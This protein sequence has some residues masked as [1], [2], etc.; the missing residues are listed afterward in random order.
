MEMNRERITKFRLI[1]IVQLLEGESIYKNCEISFHCVVNQCSSLC[2]PLYVNNADDDC[3]LQFP[4]LTINEEPAEFML[5][6]V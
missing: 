2:F 3:K 6:H 1:D 4:S 5:S